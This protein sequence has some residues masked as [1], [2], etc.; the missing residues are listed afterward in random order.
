[1]LKL[2]YTKKGDENMKIILSERAKELE[3]TERAF[4]E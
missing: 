3:Q 1:M 2:I 4:E